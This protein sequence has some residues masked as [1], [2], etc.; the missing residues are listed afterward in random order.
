MKSSWVFLLFITA[1]CGIACTSKKI[2]STG[3]VTLS[4]D[5]LSYYIIKDKKDLDP[6]IESIGNAQIVLL[7]ESTHGTKEFYNWRSA[8]TQRLIREKN[9][10][11][12]AVEGDW[13]DAS[14]VNNLIANYVTDTTEIRNLLLRFDRWPASLWANEQVLQ[15]LKWLT[16]YQKNNTVQNLH[17]YGLDLYN[18]W[19]CIQTLPENISATT[20]QTAAQAITFFSKYKGDALRYSRDP[21]AFSQGQQLINRLTQAIRIESMDQRFTA[22]EKCFLEQV[23]ALLSSGERYFRLLRSDRQTALNSRDQYMAATIQRLSGCP[24]PGSKIIVWLHNTHTGNVAYSAYGNSGYTS[25]AK[26]LKETLGEKAVF[27]VGFGTYKGTVLAGYSWYAPVT[28][29]RVLP[30]KGDTWEDILHKLNHNDKLILSRDLIGK[31]NWERW[32]EFRS[33]GATYQDAAT[34]SRSIIPKRFDAFIF[35]DSTSAIEP[36]HH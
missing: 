5:T 4:T 1:F 17:Y 26:I 18:F 7:G 36:L 14:F 16:E 30:A 2:H 10:T 33:I 24:V 32:I 15:F 13:T 28:V 3:V 35:I 20:K 22:S 6:L 9:F 8:I 27:S 34:Y 31:P 23:V 21:Q 11:S 12:V 19:A 25:V 29:R